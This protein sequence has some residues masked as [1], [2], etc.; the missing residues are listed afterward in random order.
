MKDNLNSMGR[1]VRI[2]GA[3]AFI[4]DSPR[5]GRHSALLSARLAKKAPLRAAL[6]FTAP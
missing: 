5:A 6:R 3:C 2:G 4:G 1:T